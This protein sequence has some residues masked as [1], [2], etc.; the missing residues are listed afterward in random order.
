MTSNSETRLDRLERVVEQLATTMTQQQ[1]NAELMM[2]AI[3]INSDQIVI[4]QAEV[5]DLQAEMRD[6]QAQMLGMQT[7]TRRILDNLFGEEE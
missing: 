5:R 6:M 7:E 3:R 2:Q 4:L 1:Q